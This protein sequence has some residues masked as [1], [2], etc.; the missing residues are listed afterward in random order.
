MGL[1]PSH[2]TPG[3]S[4]LP[5]LVRACPLLS[6]SPGLQAGGDGGARPLRRLRSHRDAGR[7]LLQVGSPQPC[8][9][10]PV[11]ALAGTGQRG[12]TCAGCHTAWGCGPVAAGMSLAGAF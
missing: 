3:P 7:R 6:P 12:G 2:S 4:F 1:S 9:L 11:S 10:A 8:C 5:S